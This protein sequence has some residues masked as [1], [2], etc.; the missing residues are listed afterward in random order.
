MS[1]YVSTDNF[2]QR[3][4]EKGLYVIQNKKPDFFSIHIQGG[5]SDVTNFLNK[6]SKEYGVQQIFETTRG[7][8]I[9]LVLKDEFKEKE[10]VKVSRL[11]G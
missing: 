5:H 3:E 11:E 9:F 6:N 10:I 1:V 2:T 7:F 8:T 4:R